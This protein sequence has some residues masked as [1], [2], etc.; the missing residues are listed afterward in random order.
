MAARKRKCRDCDTMLM[1]GPE[2]F[3]VRRVTS[4]G[5]VS[6]AYGCRKCRAAK[7]RSYKRHERP[8]VKEKMRAAKLL[9]DYGIT[10]DEF[11]AMLLEQG[12]VCA[13]C[14]DPEKQIDSRSGVV[15]QLAVDHDHST[16][17]VRGLL[18]GDCNKGLGMFKDRPELLQAAID[19]ILENAVT[20]RRELI[21]TKRFRSPDPHGKKGTRT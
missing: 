14:K 12:G 15:R 13:I 11:D 8:E 4:S 19:Y 7:T 21:E 6:E 5:R 17:K 18:C 20:Q 9:S 10:K 16:G 2:S 3:T 1:G